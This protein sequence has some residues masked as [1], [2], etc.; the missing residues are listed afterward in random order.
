M[1]ISSSN[2]NE[3]VNFIR[4]SFKNW[5]KTL[6]FPFEK[7]LQITNLKFKKIFTKTW[8]N[9]ALI[10]SILTYLIASSKERKKE[11][12]KIHLEKRKKKK[13]NSK[14]VFKY[15]FSTAKN[16]SRRDKLWRRVEEDRK[17]LTLWPPSQRAIESISVGSGPSKRSIVHS[18]TERFG[19]M[20]DLMSRIPTLFRV[21][22]TGLETRGTKTE[23][24]GRIYFYLEHRKCGD[25]P[26]RLSR[27]FYGLSSRWL[28]DEHTIELDRD[29]CM[30]LFIRVSS[31]WFWLNCCYNEYCR[32]SSIR[33]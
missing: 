17:K 4:N 27:P 26:P 10:L 7:N 13:K 9:I 28:K 18:V 33:E 1:E 2:S 24:K 29:P 25:W 16:G 12:E 15:S 30:G 22:L 6:K 14:D 3:L 19:S 5:E 20:E 11:G 21:T 23:R 31:Y 32:Y 8:K